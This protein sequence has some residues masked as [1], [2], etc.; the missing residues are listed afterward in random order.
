MCLTRARH[1]SNVENEQLGCPAAVVPLTCAQNLAAFAEPSGKRTNP[2]ERSI[3]RTTSG[4]VSFDIAA[5][6]WLIDFR[7]ALFVSCQT[8]RF[9]QAKSILSMSVSRHCAV[10]MPTPERT[11]QSASYFI[12]RQ[13][14]ATDRAL[15]QVSAQTRSRFDFLGHSRD[16]TGRTDRTAGRRHGRRPQQSD[17]GVVGPSVLARPLGP[18]ALPTSMVVI[19]LLSRP[20]RPLRAPATEP[21]WRED[22]RSGVLIDPAF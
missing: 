11:R 6:P 1:A 10:V 17:A 2:T 7:Y 15:S 4:T 22:A 19:S 16:F 13:P 9:H 20:G 8:A 21:A 12:A 18:P 5:S 3:I 14:V